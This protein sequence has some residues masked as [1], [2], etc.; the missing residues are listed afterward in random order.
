MAF[1]V[2]RL[3]Q[4]KLDLI[5]LKIGQ[6][7][8][9]DRATNGPQIW[10]ECPAT[11]PIREPDRDLIIILHRTKCCSSTILLPAQNDYP[12]SGS[13]HSTLSNQLTFR[14]VHGHAPVASPIEKLLSKLCYNECLKRSTYTYHLAAH[15]ERV[16]LNSE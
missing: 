7:S 10:V 5:R 2:E 11:L 15:P 13:A 12:V 14:L 9:R 16:H 3:R 1:Y 6:L 4:E 8:N